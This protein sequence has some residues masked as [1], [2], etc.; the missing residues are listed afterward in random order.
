MQQIYRR[1]PIL[2]CD[3]NKVALQLYRNYTS[4]WVLSCKFVAYIQNRFLKEHLHRVASVTLTLH[5]S[6]R[7][8]ADFASHLCLID[9]SVTGYVNM[10]VVM[11]TWTSNKIPRSYLRRNFALQLYW[12][13][14]SACVFPCKFVAYF[15]NSF[16]K[17]HLWRVASVTFTLHSSSPWHADFASDSCLIDISLRG[18]ANMMAVT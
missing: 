12:N 4:A 17:E 5:S 13:Y 10:M 15:Q 8:H 16:L 9:I 2:K 18:Y 6:S 7:W 3:F 1:T 11:Q 14:T